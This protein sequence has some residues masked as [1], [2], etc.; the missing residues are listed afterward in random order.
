M[1]KAL[2]S[3]RA[4]YLKLLWPLRLKDAV[5]RNFYSR[6]F[7]ARKSPSFLGLYQVGA[8]H[9]SYHL[10][11]SREWPRHKLHG[12]FLAWPLSNK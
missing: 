7:F 2:P 6:L 9:E 8:A 4:L 1:E 12:S 5:H 3:Y 11:T 10:T